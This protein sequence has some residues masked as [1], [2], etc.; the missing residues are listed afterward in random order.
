MSRTTLASS[1]DDYALRVSIPTA[2]DELTQPQ[3]RYVLTLLAAGI[4]VE[5]VMVYC[6]FRFAG[7]H[8]VRPF[9]EDN[10]LVRRRHAPFLLHRADILAAADRL[11][12]LTAPPSV[13][14]RL[15][16]WQG[17]PAVDA[18]L[19]GVP[20]GEYLQ[21]ENHFQQYLADTS[22]ARPL[23][24]LGK[25]LYPKFRG[26]CPSKDLPLFSLNL[27]VWLTGLKRLFARLFPDLFRP[28]SAAAEPPDLRTVML[29][30]IRAL[31][32]GDVTKEAAVLNVDTWTA[33]AELNEKAR[34][35][36]EIEAI[37]KK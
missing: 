31:T 20:F 16:R 34:E 36:R 14:L 32:G 13:P 27:L 25:I 30:E 28:S 11:A 18:A 23:S 24:A 2:W 9:G 33:L 21:A 10:L 15:A 7:L 29:A 1:S 37:R 17:A 8:V 4:A 3:L 22:S 26:K 12:F 5:R 6:F 35:A 19:H